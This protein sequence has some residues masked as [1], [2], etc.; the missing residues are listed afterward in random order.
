MS[1]LDELTSLATRFPERDSRGNVI[2]FYV[3]AGYGT[4]ERRVSGPHPA[5]VAARVEAEEQLDGH[6]KCGHVFTAAGTIVNDA[7]PDTP[8]AAQKPTPVADPGS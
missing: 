2:G 3:Y 8:T 7:Q 1:S 4:A 5:P 6:V